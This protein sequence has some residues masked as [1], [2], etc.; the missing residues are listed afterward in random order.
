MA[1]DYIFHVAG[2]AVTHFDGVSVEYFVVFVVLWEILLMSFR[3]REPILVM[4]FLLYG[5]LNRIISRFLLLLVELFGRLL[6]GE[7]FSVVL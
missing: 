5:G 3:K 2:A 1:V 7:Y 6:E 4:M